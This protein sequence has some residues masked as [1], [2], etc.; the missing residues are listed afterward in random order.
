MFIDD[1]ITELDR[2]S[3]AW[4]NHRLDQAMY[5]AWGVIDT[6]VRCKPDVGDLFSDDDV[7]HFGQ[8][9]FTDSITFR[10]GRVAAIDAIQDAWQQYYRDK[11]GIVIMTV[12]QP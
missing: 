5:Y 3:V 9:I 7:Y 8:K 4:C 6:L 10:L 2:E 11:F 12:V 1:R